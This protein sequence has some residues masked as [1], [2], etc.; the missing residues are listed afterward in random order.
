[1]M[2]MW[3]RNFDWVLIGLVLI[4]ASISLV[5][6]AS[7]DSFYFTRQLIWYVFALVIVFL[8]SQIRW[9]WLFTQSWFRHGF[10][11]VTIVL[12]IVPYLQGAIIRGTKSWIIIGEFQFA[13]S[14]LAKI[15][16]IIILAGFFSRRYLAAWQSKNIFLSL[17]YMFIPVGLTALQPDLGSALVM[18]GIWLGFLLMSGINKKRFVAGLLI[19]LILFSVL[20]IYALKPYQ[21]DRIIGF[22]FPESDPLGINYNLIQSK[23]AI[24]SAGLWGKGFGSGTQTQLGF[25]PE[26]HTDFLFAAFVEEWGMAGGIVLLLTYLGFIFRITT[27]GLR[28][29]RNDAKFVVLGVGLF[30]LIHFFVNIGSNIGVVP[31]I[32][33]GLPFVSYGGSNLLTS[34]LLLSIIERIKLKSS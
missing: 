23:I 19:A 1:M 29:R 12:L 7:I 9:Q 16:L 10:Y 24:G 26:A 30:F 31:I 8:G 33:I 28:L 22:L 34:A 21:K 3:V 14:E 32:G 4:L 2:R 17:F 13:P 25:L 5:T 27:I 15:A 11:W 6:L 18:V 20:W